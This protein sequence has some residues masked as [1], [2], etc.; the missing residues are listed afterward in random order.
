MKA[1]RFDD[2]LRLVDNAPLPRRDGEALIQVLL[3]G[4]CNTD[5]EITKGYAGFHGVPGHEFVGR[6][7]EAPSA[8]VV[9]RRVVGEINVGCNQCELCRTGDARHCETRTVLGIKDRDGAFAEFLSLPIRNLLEVPDS[10]P[11]EAAVFVEPLAAANHIL[12]AVSIDRSSNVAVIGDGKLG[13]LIVQVLATT[14]CSISAVGKHDEKLQLARSRGASCFTW[15]GS[16]GLNALP[17]DRFDVV[18]EASGSQTGLPLALDL[19]RPRGVIILKTTHH[20]STPVAMAPLVVNE[21]RVL[22]SRCGRFAPALELLKTGAVDVLPLISARFSLDDG[23]LAF[24][25]AA[26]R[27]VLKAILKIAG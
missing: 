2:E 10:V 6:V 3:A 13:Q 15:N 24:E 18:I 22:G 23:L 25:A 11:D 8:T 26:R 7:V 21:V 12:D 14:G 19:V 4:I 20:G 27:D 16:Q 5:L 1:L 17:P 9:G